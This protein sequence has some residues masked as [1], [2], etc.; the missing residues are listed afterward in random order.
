MLNIF[1]LAFLLTLLM[2]GSWSLLGLLM[3][4]IESLNNK[5]ILYT[6]GKA[7]IIITGV[8]GTI[9]HELGHLLMCL[10]FRHRVIE[11][12]LFKPFSSLS[13]G[14]LGYVS[15]SYN[16]N[17]IYQQ[18]GNFFIGIAPLVMGTITI[19]MSFR[20]LLPQSYSSFI[21]SLNL[22]SIEEK[23]AFE[24]ISL[25][26]VNLTS[27]LNTIFNI[28]NIQTVNF[29]IFILLMYCIST[30]MSL[31]SADLKNS[32][33]GLMSI[34][35]LCLGISIVSIVIGYDITQLYSL[36]IQYNI[37]VVAFLSMGTLFS[38]VTLLLSYLGYKIKI[39]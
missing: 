11:V 36:L 28:S 9:I 2:V 20:F 32:F 21:I 14:V 12:K 6:W 22:V 37:G 25:I 13:D 24:F 33:V 16:K 30:H 29:W 34:F 7:G 3:D 5:Y 1:Q 26:V 10:L 4:K 23:T 31:S 15:H 17:S 38:T 27:L 39:K 35:F 18:I 19:F 8:I